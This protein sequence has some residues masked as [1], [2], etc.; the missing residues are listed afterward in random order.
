EA[1]QP[2]NLGQEL[3][4]LT[5]D[6]AAGGDVLQCRVSLLKVALRFITRTAY[7]PCGTVVLAVYSDKIHLG[8]AFGRT[9][10]QDG[11]YIALVDGTP[12]YV[13]DLNTDFTSLYISW[14][15]GIQR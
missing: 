5:A 10:A 7:A 13:G 12:A 15:F 2:G 1:N 11:P 3:G 9:I 8:V 6:V 14:C 4:F